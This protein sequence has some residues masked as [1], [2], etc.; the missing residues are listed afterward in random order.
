MLNTSIAS[1]SAGSR[2]T[3]RE[4]CRIL[5]HRFPFL[6]IDQLL[7]W[8]RGKSAIGIKNVTM[9]EMHF[10]GHFPDEP[11]MPG[12][13]IIEM[14]AQT[15]Y[16][17]EVLSRTPEAAPH[18][19]YLNYLGSVNVR[20]MKPVIPG[21]QLQS[22]VEIIKQIDGGILANV[23]AHVDGVPVAAGELIVIAKTTPA[24]PAQRS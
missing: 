2:V 7:T 1:M 22:K 6:M 12:V 14:M 20:F 5:P 23:F 19:Q 24:P 17:L 18:S 21:D 15:L 3:S 8:E 4:L 16:A 10:L 11:V 13:L 9:N